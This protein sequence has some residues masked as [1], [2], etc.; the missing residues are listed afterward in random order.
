MGWTPGDVS[1][2]ET[3]TE[4]DH[5]YEQHINELRESMPAL[6]VGRTPNCQYYCDGVADDVQIQQALTD[7]AG[8]RVI[9][10][11]GVYDI[12]A[13]LLYDTNTVIEGCG[14]ATQLKAGMNLNA[15]VLKSNGRIHDTR[16]RNL[17][18]EGNKANQSLSGTGIEVNGFYN[19]FEN[20]WAINCKTYGIYLSATVNSSENIIDGGR[21]NGDTYGIYLN[22]GNVD[23]IVRDVTAYNGNTCIYS[24]AG[25]GRY[26]NII[27]FGASAQCFYTSKQCEIDNIRLGDCPIGIYLDGELNNIYGIWSGV[28]IANL[29]ATQITDHTIYMYSGSGETALLSVFGWYGNNATNEDLSLDGPGMHR[30]KI[31]SNYTTIK[32]EDVVGSTLHATSVI[33]QPEFFTDTVPTHPVRG[34]IYLDD[35]TNTG[36]GKPTYRRYWGGGWDDISPVGGDGSFVAELGNNKIAQFN[37]GVN[38]SAI[39]G[40]NIGLISANS[41]A[42]LSSRSTFPFVFY[43]GGTLNSMTPGN[44]VFRIGSDFVRIKNSKTPASATATGTAGDIC[45]DTDYV[46]VCVA[47]NTWKRSPLTTW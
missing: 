19:H 22:S 28:T 46:Y 35:G 44:E 43:I 26:A 21:Y 36:S 17:Y 38:G 45:W 1:G 8:K 4:E 10:L 31:I 39:W 2:S 13:T 23:Y 25:A 20:V 16:V 40:Q 27:L 12:T 33:K 18:I 29:S 11:P 15:P 6:I 9:I 7:G 14:T 24:K 47:T 32:A 37:D 3:L 30:L 41:E 5:I 42:K 34:M